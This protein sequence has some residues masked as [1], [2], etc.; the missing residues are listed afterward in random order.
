M[1]AATIA[2]ITPLKRVTVVDADIDIRDPSHVDWALNARFSP[3]RDTVLI[4][5]WYVPVQM[6]PSVRDA[7]GNVA[8]GSKLVLDATQKSDSGS[9]SLPPKELMMEALALWQDAGLPE[10]DIPPRLKLRLDKS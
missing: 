2:D 6:D 3:Q 1:S 5:D 8:A 10:I 7:R 4:D 9:F